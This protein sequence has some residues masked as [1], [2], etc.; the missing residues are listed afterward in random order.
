MPRRCR[1]SSTILSVFPAS[2]IAAHWHCRTAC[3]GVGSRGVGIAGSPRSLG[4]VERDRGGGAL[5]LIHERRVASRYLGRYLEGE[6]EKRDGVAINVQLL[7]AEHDD[8]SIGG[9]SEKLP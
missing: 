1:S 5:E 6:R 3:D 4:N 2:R 9:R 8:R 7:A